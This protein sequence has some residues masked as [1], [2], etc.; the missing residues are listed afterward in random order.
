M[1]EVLALP[2]LISDWKLDIAV[3]RPLYM[4]RSTCAPQKPRLD[5]NSLERRMVRELSS[6]CSALMLPTGSLTARR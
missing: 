6:R 5:K 3:S 4:Q 2:S 1:I